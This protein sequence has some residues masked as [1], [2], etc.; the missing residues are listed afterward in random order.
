MPQTEWDNEKDRIRQVVDECCAKISEHCGAVQI[1]VSYHNHEA[2]TMSYEKG[3]G[4]F[5]A[6]LGAIAEWMEVQRQYAKNWAIRKD[7]EDE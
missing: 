3:S 6:R 5:H 4:S 1:I 2:G 7:N